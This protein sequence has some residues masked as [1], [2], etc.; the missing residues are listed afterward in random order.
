M[1]IAKAKLE[2]LELLVPIFDAY[3]V[4]YRQTSD[5]DKCREFLY[6]RISKDE[7]TI[8]IALNENGEGM[9]FT[10]L[11]PTFSS[12][13]RRKVFIL[14]D[15]YVASEYRRMGVATSLMNKAIEFG[16]ENN[17]VRLHLETEKTNI[18]AQA[19]YEREGWQRDNELFSY[20]YTL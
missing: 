10:Q 16:R 9:G 5:Q 20:D 7:S 17:C 4:F 6:Q 19:L 2:D 18:N 11:Y 3:L 15:L 8:F 1:K 13:S 14:N 12:V